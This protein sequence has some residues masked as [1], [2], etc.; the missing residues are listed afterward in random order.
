M[1]LGEFRQPG[2]KRIVAFALEGDFDPA[3]LKSNVVEIDWPPRS[4]R[5]LTIPEVDRAAWFGLEA[6][7]IKLHKGQRPLLA[8][9]AR[10]IGLR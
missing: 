5:R 6:A 9:F 8:A 1:P 3:T 2:G 10:D 4:G 7:A